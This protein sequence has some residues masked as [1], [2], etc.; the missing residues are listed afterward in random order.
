MYTCV[1]YFMPS[2]VLM[3]GEETQSPIEMSLNA[4]TFRAC[5]IDV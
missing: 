5:I 3:V 4:M 1:K 2:S